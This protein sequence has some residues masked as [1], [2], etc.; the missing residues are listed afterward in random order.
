VLAALE[1]LK[2]IAEKNGITLGQL[3]LAWV[4]SR[5]GNCCAIA[6]ARNAAQA[7]QNAAAA[8]AGLSET[9]LAEMDAIGRSVTD[10]LDA[11]PVLWKW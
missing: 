8:D 10:L 3:A 2:P 5:P 7:V 4:L 6:G 9:D 1:R 11:D